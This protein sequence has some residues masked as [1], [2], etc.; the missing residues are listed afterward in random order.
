MLIY[1]LQNDDGFAC[2]CVVVEY[3]AVDDQHTRPYTIEAELMDMN[4]MRE[5]LWQLLQS[6]RLCY[7]KVER[8]ANPPEGYGN[9]DETDNVSDDTDTD[10]AEDANDPGDEVEEL[11]EQEILRYQRSN[12]TALQTFDALFK[13]QDKLTQELLVREDGPDPEAEILEMLVHK[14]SKGLSSRTEWPDTTQHTNTSDSL[15]ECR[16]NLDFLTTNPKTDQPAI[17]PFIKL[18]RF[19]N[20]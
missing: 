6:V 7:F 15:D 20:F 4:E 16:R 8:A 19:V 1:Y 14:A 12:I 11:D 10:D 2:T 3:R 9:T 5:L 18:I 13:G 17:W